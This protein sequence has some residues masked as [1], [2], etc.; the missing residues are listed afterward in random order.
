MYC[1]VRSNANM[2]QGEIAD[3]YFPF[4]RYV[5]KKSKIMFQ[6]AFICAY[7][8]AFQILDSCLILRSLPYHD[9]QIVHVRH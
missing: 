1:S 4:M 3:M 8:N 9:K 2:L 7:Y 6:K 5:S